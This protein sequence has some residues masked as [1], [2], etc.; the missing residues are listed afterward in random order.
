MAGIAPPALAEDVPQGKTINLI[1]G[2]DA[3]GGFDT[4]S[5]ALMR[6]MPKYLPG[7]PNIVLQ[8]MPG[9]TGITATNHLYNV[10]AKDGSV[11]GAI[12]NSTLYEPLYGNQNAKYEPAKF[13]WLGSM[14]KQRPICVTW[15]TS[16][17]KTLDDAKKRIVAV[18][19]S[20]N[21]SNHATTPRLLNH[22]LG[23]K[24]KVIIGYDTSGARLAVERGEVDGVCGLSYQTLIAAQPD[25]FAKKRVNI[26]A[27]LGIGDSK[28][29]DLKGVPNALGVVPNTAD[30][31]ALELLLTTQEMGRPYVAP[32]GMAKDRLQMLRT[33]FD[34]TME[35]DGFKA[36]AEK[37]QLI[38]EPLSGAEMTRM[39]E[40]AYGASPATVARAVD[41]A[42]TSQTAEK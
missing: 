15:G 6:T 12:S 9:A 20:S 27:Q 33:A 38:I 21:T 22:L 3:G 29:P 8:Y 14:G 10:A 19:A 25:W 5:R 11:F 36:D 7:Q 39:L 1:I 41:L 30:R 26:I 17:I 2:S 16:D 4:Y 24:F 23:T 35:D 42:R 34:K 28:A 31:E 37:M 13:G 32:P 18:S 40:R